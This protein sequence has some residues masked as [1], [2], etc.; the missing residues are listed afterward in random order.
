MKSTSSSRTGPSFVLWTN[1]MRS[2]CG[3][4]SDDRRDASDVGAEDEVGEADLLPWPLD[5]SAAGAGSSE[6]IANESAERGAAG[7][8]SGGVMNGR[9]AQATSRPRLKSLK[10]LNPVRQLSGQ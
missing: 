4:L 7:A 9:A 6:R 3:Q 1:V 5:S 8:V 2:G 10:I